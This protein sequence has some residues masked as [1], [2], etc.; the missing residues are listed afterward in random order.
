MNKN[1]EDLIKINK[2]TQG[3]VTMR[4]LAN[5]SLAFWCFC[6]VLCATTLFADTKQEI[7]ARN[8]Q[9]IQAEQ[10][11]KDQPDNTNG[12]TQEQLDALLEQKRIEEEAAQSQSTS[13]VIPESS[14]NEI[15]REAEEAKW[16][17]H[18]AQTPPDIA[19]RLETENINSDEF[20]ESN[21]VQSSQ[22]SDPYHDVNINNQALENALNK[23][24]EVTYEE[25]LLQQKRE[26]EAL[27]AQA[28]EAQALEAEAIENL[29]NPIKSHQKT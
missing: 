1:K 17:E 16:L 21:E 19:P 18:Q 14:N 22:S 4:T 3:G 12:L 24:P 26:A 15:D 7:E 29:V 27:E 2:E 11:A 20:Q 6:I 8:N 9:L 10:D 23:A 5:K 25:Y 13:P 28:K